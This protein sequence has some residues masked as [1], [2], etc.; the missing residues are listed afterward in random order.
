MNATRWFRIT[1]KSLI[2]NCKFTR[3]YKHN[4]LTETPKISRSGPLFKIPIGCS[5]P[6]SKGKCCLDKKDFWKFR[7]LLEIYDKIM[8]S[9]IVSDSVEVLNFQPLGS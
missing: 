3:S 8:N 1:L 2:T 5:T 6:W 9:L 7:R 4:L